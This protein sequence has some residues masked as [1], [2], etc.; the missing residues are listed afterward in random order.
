MIL[1]YEPLIE[2]DTSEALKHY[3]D[4]GG[5]LTEHDKTREF[6]AELK[7][8]IGQGFCSVVS[9]GTISLSIAL[10]AGGVKPGDEV[11]VPA[12][13][14]VAT[15]NAVKLIGATPVFADVDECDLCLNFSDMMAKTTPKTKG[16]IYVTL[17]GRHSKIMDFA[18]YCHDRNMIYV[19]DDAQSLGSN[20]Y[21]GK[22]IGTRADIA[23]FSFSMP[24]IITT[25][26]GGCLYTGISYY[27]DRIKKLRDFGREKSGADKYLEFGINAKFSDLQAVVGLSQIATMKDRIAKKK[28]IFDLYRDSLMGVPEV[29]FLD[30]NLNYVTP[31]FVDIYVDNRENLINHLKEKG[32][33]SRP[34]YPSIPRELCYNLDYPFP[35][36]E[37]ASARGLWLP[38]SL[39]LTG[40]QIIFVCDQIKEYYKCL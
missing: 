12:L 6:E 30:T 34:I 27:A 24:K 32:I 8:W 25:G 36:T 39:T 14:M 33:G 22:F 3:V 23:S 38:S 17:N 29:E 37:K 19:E 28:Y 18:G 20:Y 11:I 16:L 5:W 26:Q 4:G 15:A 9:N 1:Q 13:T 2:K 35:I 21:G 40:E 7:K 10:L 31:W